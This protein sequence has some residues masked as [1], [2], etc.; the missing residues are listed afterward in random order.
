MINCFT[1]YQYALDIVERGYIFLN[2]WQILELISLKD[3]VGTTIEKVKER[4]KIIYQNNSLISDVLDALFYKRNLL[5]HEGKL[6]DFTLN[7]VN[8]IKTIAE[9]AINFLF[10]QVNRFKNKRNLE[11]FYDNI[12]HNEIHE[13]INKIYE[14]GKFEK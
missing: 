2:F 7:D 1:L 14:T 9:G 5:V 6:E 10:G 4:I 8:Q 3:P 13:I 12:K 11:A